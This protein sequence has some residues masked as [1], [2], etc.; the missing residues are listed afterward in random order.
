MVY[1]YH[2]VKDMDSS[3]RDKG[4]DWDHSI[5]GSYTSIASG[6]GRDRVHGPW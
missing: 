3:T 2:R 6:A 1:R 4:M 5:P